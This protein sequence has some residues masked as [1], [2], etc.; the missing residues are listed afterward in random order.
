MKKSS[1]A[2]HVWEPSHPSTSLDIKHISPETYQ[3]IDTIEEHLIP[4]Q[5][6]QRGMVFI[7]DNSSITWKQT[8]IFLC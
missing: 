8:N 4:K 1:K 3:R 7:Y 6:D 2:D 5:N